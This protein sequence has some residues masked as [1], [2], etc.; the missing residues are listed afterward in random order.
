MIC[1]LCGAALGGLHLGC[2]CL[3]GSPGAHGMF[4][5][6]WLWQVLTERLFLQRLQAHNIAKHQQECALHAEFITTK[7]VASIR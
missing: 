2:V 3:W 7:S 1:L 6:W 4:W 5:E